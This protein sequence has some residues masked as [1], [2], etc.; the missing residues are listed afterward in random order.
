MVRF[1]EDKNQF[2]SINVFNLKDKKEAKNNRNINSEYVFFK[3]LLNYYHLGR[4]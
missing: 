2:L 4:D 3:V 1:A